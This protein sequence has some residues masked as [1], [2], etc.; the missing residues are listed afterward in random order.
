MSQKK[1]TDSFSMSL[2]KLEAR[3]STTST[4]MH[5]RHR[6]MRNSTCMRWRKLVFLDVLVRLMP[7]IYLLRSAV[8]V[9]GMPTLAKN[10]PGTSRSYNATVNQRRRILHT[11]LGHPCRWNDKTLLLFDTFVRG[12]YDGNTDLK[13]IKFE[14]LEKDANG[15][16][17]TIR[18]SGCY[19]IVDNGYLSWST[20]VPPSKLQENTTGTPVV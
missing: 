8:R 4:F 12:I 14:L 1:L 9:L 15:N 3:S 17:L 16:V 10:C 13:D 11:T 2:S 18:Y 5:E 19:V 6:R 20:T 7:L